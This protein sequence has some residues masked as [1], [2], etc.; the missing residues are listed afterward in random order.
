MTLPW[1][2]SRWAV[3]G[4]AGLRPSKM[5]WLRRQP[6]LR[7]SVLV[8]LATALELTP[9]RFLHQILK[10]QQNDARCRRLHRLK[11]TRE[12]AGETRS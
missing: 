10:E 7:I 5:L 6:D 8:K 11:L 3:F 9:V 4:L 2:P 1:K 12:I